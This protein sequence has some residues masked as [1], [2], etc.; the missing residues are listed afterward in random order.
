MEAPCSITAPRM[1]DNWAARRCGLETGGRTRI[2]DFG[3]SR[4]FEVVGAESEAQLFQAVATVFKISRNVV[5]EEAVRPEYRPHRHP[6]RRLDAVGITETVRRA[7]GVCSVCHQLEA[8]TVWGCFM[9]EC[10][11]AE[12]AECHSRTS[13]VASAVVQAEWARQALVP[14]LQSAVK[15]W[16]DVEPALSSRDHAGTTTQPTGENASTHGTQDEFF[17]KNTACEHANANVP[18]QAPES[19]QQYVPLGATRV[20]VEWATTGHRDQTKSGDSVVT[21]AGLRGP[22]RSTLEY[23]GRRGKRPK[24][25]GSVVNESASVLQ[26]R[27]MAAAAAAEP[28]RLD[29]MTGNRQPRRNRGRNSVSRS[30]ESIAAKF[31]QSELPPAVLSNADAQFMEEVRAQ[32][33]QYT[34]EVCTPNSAIKLKERDHILK[35]HMSCDELFCYGIFDSTEELSKHR[36]SHR[37]VSVPNYEL[38]V[39][40]DVSLTRVFFWLHSSKLSSRPNPTRIKY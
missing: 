27:S 30:F 24:T 14:A 21:D 16:R 13:T 39:E 17:T 10:G 36:E 9:P 28:T 23:G 19:Q 20:D 1:S 33:A 7:L 40:I 38:L 18:Q 4:W 37:G 8:N 5:G 15:V 35:M 2:D 32:S 11:H 34:A 3:S 12:C 26:P 22:K 29:G 6:L 31:S 25:L